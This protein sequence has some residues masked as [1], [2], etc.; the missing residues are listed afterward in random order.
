MLAAGHKKRGVGSGILRPPPRVPRDTPDASEAGRLRDAKAGRNR[1]FT[2][3]RHFRR[4][5]APRGAL[6]SGGR[7]VTSAGRAPPKGHSPAAERHH[8]ARDD[9]PWRALT[10][11]HA[12]GRSGPRLAPPRKRRPGTVAGSSPTGRA[13]IHK[14]TRA[15]RG[16]IHAP[17]GKPGTR[18]RQA[19]TQRPAF[20][21][22]RPTAAARCDSTK[23]PT[24]PRSPNP[25]QNRQ[26]PQRAPS[27]LV[28]NSPPRSFPIESIIRSLF[29]KMQDKIR[30]SVKFLV[31]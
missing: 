14:A 23:E 30:I 8:P 29:A 13:L 27:H 10:P 20:L 6:A 22:G 15:T 21:A 17:C 2:F 5:G 3:A 18:R 26:H 16:T 12:A 28:S 11:H 4:T 19:P 7:A 25:T 31:D 1:T 9:C 24:P